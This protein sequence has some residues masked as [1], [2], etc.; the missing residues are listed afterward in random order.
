MLFKFIQFN[1]YSIQFSFIQ[2]NSVL[3]N[4]IFIQLYS[5]L[6]NSIQFY[7]IQFYSIQFLFNSIQIKFEYGD[8]VGDVAMGNGIDG[9]FEVRGMVE[10]RTAAA[11]LPLGIRSIRRRKRHQYGQDPAQNGRHPTDDGSRRSGP[12]RRMFRHPHPDG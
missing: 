12:P 6:F 11:A 2:F 4:S 9:Q 10:R 7:S 8:C 3:F 1:L 5:T